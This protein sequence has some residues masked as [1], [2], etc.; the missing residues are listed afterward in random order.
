MNE[1]NVPVLIV[2]AALIVIGVI[3]LFRRIGAMRRSV[4]VKQIL[5]T[6]MRP[7]SLTHA[8]RDPTQDKTSIERMLKGETQRRDESVS[9]PPAGSGR[10][11]ATEQTFRNM[12]FTTADGGEGLIEYYMKR[13]QCDRTAAMRYAIKEREREARD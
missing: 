8:P 1:S 11:P 12:F 2:V 3:L 10:D 7:S 13:Y 4:S 6:E 5:K 9:R